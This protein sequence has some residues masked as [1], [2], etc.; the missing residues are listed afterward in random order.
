MAPTAVRAIKK[1]DFAGKLIPDLPKLEAVYLAGERCD[2]MTIRWL[3]EKL[4]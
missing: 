1:E 4:P 3:Q 2:P